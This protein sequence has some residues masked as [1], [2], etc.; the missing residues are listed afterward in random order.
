MLSI[1]TN[2]FSFIPSTI[3]HFKCQEKYV[4]KFELNPCDIFSICLLGHWF[5]TVLSERSKVLEIYDPNPE[6]LSNDFQYYFDIF[7]ANLELSNFVNFKRLELTSPPLL[8]RMIPLVVECLFA[9][10]CIK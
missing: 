2:E 8:N 4:Y 7:K 5:L 3:S 9:S 1:N 6:T 10:M